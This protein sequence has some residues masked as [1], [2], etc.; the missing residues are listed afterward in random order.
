VSN[1]RVHKIT[2]QE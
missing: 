2:I 1:E